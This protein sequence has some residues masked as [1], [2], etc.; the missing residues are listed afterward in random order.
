MVF[1][2]FCPYSNQSPTTKGVLLYLLLPLFLPK[3]SQ[4]CV[5]S[6]FALI[7][8]KALP[9]RVFFALILESPLPKAAFFSIFALILTKA[10]QKG[11]FLYFALILTKAQQKIVFFS[12][13]ALVLTKALPKQ[14]FFLNICFNLMQ[15]PATKDVFFIFAL[16]LGKA[17]PKRLFSIFLPYS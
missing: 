5:I 15:S 3:P 6:I 14:V 4:K 10:L 16:I 9:Q 17:L 7:L 8:I 2:P 12:I 1:L 13:S 11:C